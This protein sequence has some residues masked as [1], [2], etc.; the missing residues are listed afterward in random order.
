MSGKNL[1]TDDERPS[2]RSGGYAAG[3]TFRPW[4]WVWREEKRT[5]GILKS[6]SDCEESLQAYLGKGTWRGDTVVRFGRVGFDMP[7]GLEGG[8]S[9]GEL[10][11]RFHG[12][13]TR[14]RIGSVDVTAKGMCVSK[15]FNQE[16]CESVEKPK[17][18]KKIL[19]NVAQ[20]KEK[21]ASEASKKEVLVGR[22][23]EPAGARE[24]TESVR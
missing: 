9:A 21:E 2:R 3:L 1:D 15:V 7:E 5:Q 18:Q 24:I 10:H 22:G 11:I 20:A 19:W 16:E 14:A 8:T 12:S 13:R 6:L 4:L 17:A 23:E